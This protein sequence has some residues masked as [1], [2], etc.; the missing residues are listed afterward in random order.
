[1]RTRPA[2]RKRQIPARSP[3][4]ALPRGR[5][6]S[7]KLDG[8]TMMFRDVSFVPEPDSPV[9]T[10][11]LFGRTSECIATLAGVLA[12]WMTGEGAQVGLA[13]VAHTLNHH[14]ARHSR[15][16]TV[17]ARD[18]AQA[19]AGLAALAAGRPAEGVAGPHEG[20]CGSGTVF[21]YSGQGS[22][23]AGMGRRLL[24][25][26]LEFAMAVAWLEPIF[27]EQVGFSLQRVL[28]DGAPVVGDARVQPVLMGLQLAL[29][30]LWRSY[31]MVPDAVVGHSMGEVTAAVVAGALTPAQ[32]LRVIAARSRLMARLA[33]QGAVA[34][35]KL[36]PATTAALIAE[37]PGVAV[38]GF[39][40]PRQ[41]VIAGP[42]AQ[43]DAVIVEARQQNRFARRLNME[44]ASHTALMDPILPELRAA[45]ADVAPK[46]LVLP[47]ISTVTDAATTPVLDADYWV[48]NMRQ[49]VRFSEAIATAGKHNA[50]FIEISPHPILTQAITE[51]LRDAH[52]HSV[53]TLWRDGDDTL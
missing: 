15:F 18:R 24:A 27:V 22:Q 12:K 23:W 50:T 33:G 32:G 34:S 31:G 30:E 39:S 9:S 26:E 42:P 38:A 3:R 13:D 11:V 28:A 47:F 4:G 17:C 8:M 35:L 41:T 36:D 21:V 40:S 10:L 20:P 46:K 29:T 37:Y 44:V 1:M 48:A 6:Q 52:H 14:R 7:F 49:P 43:V 19:V 16:A 51:T 53:G 2:R 25:D 45:L 5:I